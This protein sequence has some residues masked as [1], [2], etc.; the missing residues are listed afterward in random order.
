MQKKGSR[1]TTNIRNEPT[2]PTTNAINGFTSPTTDAITIRWNGA[3]I[4][5][6]GT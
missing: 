2:S 3:Y 6:V 1:D 5:S 4:Y